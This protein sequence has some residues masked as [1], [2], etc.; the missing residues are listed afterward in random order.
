MPRAA[1]AAT[2]HYDRGMPDALSVTSSVIE[3][4]GWFGFVVGT[5][6][7]LAGAALRSRARRYEETVAVVIPAPAYARV[8]TARWMDSW[9]D[10]HETQFEEYAIE[11]PVETE[12]TVHYDPRRPSRARTDA[13]HEDGRALSMVGRVLLSVGA[14]CAL[15]SVALLF[16]D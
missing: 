1:V 16:V 12:L 9:G 11:T 15:A 4:F 8:A 5:P 13:P 10:L 14:V 3:L 6:F 2:R 7:V